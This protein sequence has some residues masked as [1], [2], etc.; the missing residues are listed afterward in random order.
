MTNMST[1]MEQL[2]HEER[3]NSTGKQTEISK[4][5]VPAEEMD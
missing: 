2:P 1:V 3:V 4:K 5:D